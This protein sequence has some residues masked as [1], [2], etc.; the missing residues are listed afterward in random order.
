MFERTVLKLFKKLT[1]MYQQLWKLLASLQI[2][3]QVNEVLMMKLK[4]SFQLF[5]SSFTS[6]LNY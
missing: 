5:T 6:S 3:M 1:A 4:V 2:K